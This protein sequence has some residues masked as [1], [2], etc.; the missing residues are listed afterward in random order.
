L[1]STLQEIPFKLLQD[2][3]VTKVFTR[4]PIRKATLKVTQNATQTTSILQPPMENNLRMQQ[5]QTIQ[6]KHIFSSDFNCRLQL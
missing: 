1:H 2:F 3:E 4:K 5:E 6:K